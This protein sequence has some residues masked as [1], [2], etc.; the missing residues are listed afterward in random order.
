VQAVAQYGPGTPINVP[1][2]DRY[3]LHKLLVSRLR[4][5]TTESQT[6]SGKDVRQAGEL[7]TALTEK[8]P[9]EIK[10]LWER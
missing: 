6:K 2:P 9:Y 1:A 4:I 10:G 8:Y 5:A 7:I 3:A